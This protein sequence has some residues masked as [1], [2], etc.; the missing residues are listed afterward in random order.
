LGNQTQLKSIRDHFTSKTNQTIEATSSV[1]EIDV[2][3]GFTAF[4]KTK[5][6]QV[7]VDFFVHQ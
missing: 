6:F 2:R 4:E 7:P 1:Y 5:V 3:N